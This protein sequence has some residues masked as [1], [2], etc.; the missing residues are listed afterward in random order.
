MKEKRGSGSNLRAWWSC[1]PWRRW[2][3]GDGGADVG[4]DAAATM[5]FSSPTAPPLDRSRKG[6]R[7]VTVAVNFVSCAP[8]PYL[9]FIGLRDRGPS[10][11]SRLNV[12]DQDAVKG[13][14]LIV[15]SNRVRS[16]LTFS[17]LISSYTLT[18]NFDFNYFHF[19]LFHH[20]LVYRACLVVTVSRR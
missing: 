15:G 11:R 4:V 9:L 16:I 8:A 19:Y 1:W 18:L 12:P 10:T 20:K 13:S 5:D 7:A 3:R 17:P 14:D 6:G 2:R